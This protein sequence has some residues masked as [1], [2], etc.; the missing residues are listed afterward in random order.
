MEAFPE[1][2]GARS[3]VGGRVRCSC[4]AAASEADI[5]DS[6]TASSDLMIKSV[7]V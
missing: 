4:A 6:P 7:F 1:E 5:L 3:V 2:V